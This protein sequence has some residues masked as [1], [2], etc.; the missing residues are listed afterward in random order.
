MSVVLLDEVCLL[1]KT[2]KPR[3]RFVPRDGEEYRAFCIAVRV[4]TGILQERDAAG[5]SRALVA[6]LIVNNVVAQQWFG[7]S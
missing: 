5:E 7:W 4:G 3:A 2:C 1:T 6:L